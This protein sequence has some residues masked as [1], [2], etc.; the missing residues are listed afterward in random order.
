MKTAI[1]L[2]DITK[3]YSP[4]GNKFLFIDSFLQQKKSQ[5]KALNKISLKINKGEKVGIIGENGSGKTTLLK[6]INGI[7]LANSGE[8]KI[9]GRSVPLID[10]KAGFEPDLNGTENIYINGMIIGMRKK[11]IDKQLGNIIKFAELGKYIREPL[12]TYSQGMMLRL[13]FSIAIHANPDILLLDEVVGV[14][15][16][17]FQK[18][19]S[20]K[21]NDFFKQKKTI[22]IV[23]HSYDFL[24]EN[25]NRIIWIHNG[26]IIADGGK[27]ILD[28]YLAKAQN[29]IFDSNNKI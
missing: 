20:S 27:E 9:N 3:I 14:G 7:I 21:I 12:Y 15:D 28:K 8:V 19:T 2:K 29:R 1:E 4:R 6:L 18:K 23:S 26:K 16:E 24:K 5:K 11:E 13:G 22:I 25:C 17:Y 10:L